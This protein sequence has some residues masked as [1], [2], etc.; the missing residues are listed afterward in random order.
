MHMCNCIPALVV[1]GDNFGSDQGPRKHY[2]ID[3]IKIGFVRSTLQLE[4]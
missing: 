1:M 2:D 4:A 3:R